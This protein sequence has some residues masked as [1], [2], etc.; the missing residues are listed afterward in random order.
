MIKTENLIVEGKCFVTSSEIDQKGIAILKEVLVNLM[1]K[2]GYM[3]L[4]GMS[5]FFQDR[6]LTTTFQLVLAEFSTPLLMRLQRS[7]G[8]KTDSEIGSWKFLK[9]LRLTRNDMPFQVSF[10]IVP[11]QIDEKKGFTVTIRT[12]PVILFKMRNLSLRPK[13]DEFQYSDILENCRHFMNDIMMSLGSTIF[14]RPRAIAEFTGTLATEKLEKYGFADIAGLLRNGLVKNEE[15]NTEDGLT[16]LRE[17]LP[18]FI[19]DCVKKIGAESKNSIKKDLETL[20]QLGYIDK[21]MNEAIGNFLY[22]WLYSYLSAK[23]VHARER[24]SHDDAAFLF[25]VSEQIMSYM[26]DKIVLRR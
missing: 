22:V 14:E 7:I 9:A 18:K 12:E 23:P 10:S 2:N 17:A 5:L 24:L 11:I 16:N 1:D 3:C 25:S 19:S 26:L 6:F 13:L 21:W 4:D 8:T 20:M 15:G